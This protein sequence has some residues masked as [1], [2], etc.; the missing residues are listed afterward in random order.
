MSE[1]VL[2]AYATSSGA[3][4]EIAEVVAQSLR[5]SGITVE[6]QPA[7]K[8]ESLTGYHAVVLGAPLY[9]FR[10]HRDAKR[11]LRRHRQALADKPVALFAGGPW[12]DTTVDVW[13]EVRASLDKELTRFPWLT[14]VTIEVVGGRFDPSRLRF[15]FS[16]L[17]ALKQM[18][19]SDL[20][21][22]A[23]IRSWAAVLPA[24]LQLGAAR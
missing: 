20:R 24:R 23:A 1:A 15:P 12:G 7:A 10:L 16:W 19:A 22:W 3:T 21:D 5:E 11:F 17:P 4:Q 14:P 18:P 2:V 9:M 6:V 13:T 8:V